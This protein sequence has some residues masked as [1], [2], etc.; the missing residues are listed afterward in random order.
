M[1]AEGMESLT[2]TE[3]KVA[4]RCPVCGSDDVQSSA[5]AETFMYGVGENAVQIAVTVPL[6]TCPKCGYQYTDH[7]AEDLRHE[8]ICRHLGVLA[9]REIISAQEQSGLSRAAFAELAR[10]SEDTLGQWERGAIIQDGAM[11]Q[12]LYLIQFEDNIQ[13]LRD[14]AGKQTTGSGG[15]TTDE[16]KKPVLDGRAW[17]GKA[18]AYG[19]TVIVELFESR[20]HPGYYHFAMY[21]ANDS[22]CDESKKPLKAKDHNGDSSLFTQGLS[23]VL[24]KEHGLVL[25]DLMIEWAEVKPEDLPLSGERVKAGA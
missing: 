7:E 15:A 19:T 12:L 11:D 9:P 23:H 2:P 24:S 18:E 21:C 1:K 16:K 14:R 22:F 25:D 13:R 8:A 17:L 20:Q 6:R 4:L 3:A 5:T 10:V